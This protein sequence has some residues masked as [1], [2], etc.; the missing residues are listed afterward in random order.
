MA[1]KIIENPNLEELDKELVWNIKKQQW[2]TPNAKKSAENNYNLTTKTTTTNQNKATLFGTL[3]NIFVEIGK[4]IT[5]FAEGVL[6]TGIQ[7]STSKYNPFRSNKYSTETYQR[8]GKELIEEDLS[9]KFIDETLGYGKKLPSG[10]TVQET[11]DEK[12]LVKSDNLGGQVARNIGRMLPTVMVGNTAAGAVGATATMGTSAYGS[13]LEEAY[14]E[15]ASRSQAHLY[16]LGSAV[17][18]MATEWLTGGIPGVKSKLAPSLEKITKDV[19]AKS[20]SK[21]VKTLAETG[22]KASKGLTGLDTLAEKGLNQI[23]N[24]L[25]KSLLKAGYKIVGEGGE[26]ALAEML[27]PLLKNA[28]YS[29]GE[30]VDWNEVMN[31]AIVGAI[32]GGILNAPGTIVDTANAAKIEKQK[33][34]Q[35]NKQKEQAIQENKLLPTKEIEEKIEKT[36]KKGLPINEELQ[37]MAKDKIEELSISRTQ[38]KEDYKRKE[39]GLKQQLEYLTQSVVNKGHYIDKLA[40]ETGNKKLT[41]KYDRMLGANAEGQYIIGEAQ[42]D[43]NGKKIGKS[44]NEI[45]KPVEEEGLTKEFSEYLLHKHNIDRRAQGKPIFKDIT[46]RKSKQIVRLYEA[47]YPQFTKWAEDINTFNRNELRNMREAGLTSEEMEEYLNETYQ[48]YVKV[49]RDIE[50]EGP[51]K[52]EEGRKIKV[53]SPLK[54][55]TGGS[56][57]IL[58]LKDAMAAQVIKTRRAIRRNDLGLE[59]MKTLKNESE[60]KKVDLKELV[61]FDDDGG[62]F[63]VFKEGKPYEVPISKELYE[64]LSMDREI[65]LREFEQK[66]P[67]LFKPLQKGTKSQR[68]LL[69]VYHPLFTATNFFKDIGDAPFNSKYPKKFFKNYIRAIA[70]YKQQGQYYQEYTANGGNANTY[71][72]YD[73]GVVKPA[74]GARKFLEKIREVNEAI[75]MYPRLTEYISTREA[76]GTIEEALYNAAEVTTNFKRG[77][78]LTKFFN[79]NGA[80]FLNASIQGFSKQ[81]RNLTGQNGSKGYINLLMKATTF[82]ILPAVLNHLLLS[83]DEDYEDLPEYIK[84]QYYL[85]KYDDGKFIRI[86]KGRAT[87]IF[88]DVARRF[89]YLLKGQNTELESLGR[90]FVTQLAPN[91]PLEDNILAPLVGALENKTWY[92]S[93]IVPMRLQDELPKNQFDE[94]TDEISK[95][96]G[97]VFNISP[98][99]INYV[100]DQYSGGVGDVLLPLLTPQTRSNPISKKFTT[101]SV[102]YNKNVTEF[103]DKVYNYQKINNDKDATEEDKIKYKYLSSIKADVNKLYEEKRNVQMANISNKEKKELVRQIQ[104]EINLLMEDA[105]NNYEDVEKKE[106]YARIADMEYYKNSKGEWTKAQSKE[107]AEIEQLD[108]DKNEYFKVKSNI[109]KIQSEENIGYEDKKGKIIEEIINSNLNDEQKGYV[110]SK[111]YENT[112][113]ILKAKIPMNVY[114]DYQNKIKNLKTNENINKKQHIINSI[115]SLK[116]TAINKLMLYAFEGYTLS[117]EQKTKIFEHIDKFKISKQEKESILRKM[118]TFEWT[119]TGK[120]KRW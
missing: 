48:N 72:E 77:G 18:E 80:T 116:T 76:G 22:Y 117:S 84:D 78:D 115:E 112:E 107:I 97:K 15:G 52:I 119:E 79:R 109:N 89:I 10:K 58:P 44:L 95:F 98:K 13:G 47:M 16:G 71:F 12:S 5:D 61:K 53:G 105:L 14:Q 8:L 1:M 54:R 65:R 3:N 85:Y 19:L 114:L 31:S 7:L 2:E 68:N 39:R 11:L 87:S 110:Y 23:S 96:L 91:D 120:L 59:L 35:T 60:A 33:Q 118:K 62:K 38:I 17:V 93:D 25:A 102:L 28:I 32:T 113:H 103:F 75:E 34:K 111:Y 37:Q 45:W 104:E 101:D 43:I 70:E 21:L 29:Q 88:G 106:N 86:P 42:T 69:T 82:G 108:F 63:I 20:N 26:E 73:T 57:N 92:G 66:L 64:S 36:R 90:T 40:K 27:N 51:I 74:K 56:Q 83:G 41:Y 81:Y 99:K 100:L 46:S 50:N 67:I 30:K 94:K 4:G 9:Q 6:D 24:E 55:A 49:A